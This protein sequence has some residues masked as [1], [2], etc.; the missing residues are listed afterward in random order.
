[1]LPICDRGLDP[2]LVAAAMTQSRLRAKGRAKF[3]EFAEGMIFTQAGLEQSTRLTV[4]AHHAARFAAAGSTRV[5]DLGCGI[6]GDAMALGA[7]GLP[8]LA[9]QLDALPPA[10]ATRTP[11]R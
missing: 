2:E 7:L 11:A 1:A 5:A 9:V 8:V 10:G 4:A 6:G 3:G